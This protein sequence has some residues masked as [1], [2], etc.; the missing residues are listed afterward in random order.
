[1]TE[2]L[3]NI[4]KKV[5]DTLAGDPEESVNGNLT[6]EEQRAEQPQQL[7]RDPGEGLN[8]A[9]GPLNMAEV[10][11]EQDEQVDDRG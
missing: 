10:H 11:P 9:G 6:E 7:Q 1:M 2:P 4:A 8:H 3:G 5:G